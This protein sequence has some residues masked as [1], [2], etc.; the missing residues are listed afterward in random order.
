MPEEQKAI[1]SLKAA[2]ISDTKD[3]DLR[4]LF[5]YLYGLIGLL[6]ERFPSHSQEMILIDYVRSEW[7]KLRLDEIKLAYQ[8][9]ISGK[10]DVSPEHFQSFSAL[11]FGK[12]ISVYVLWASQV[13]IQNMKPFVKAAPPKWQIEIEYC[14]FRQ[15]DLKRKIN[16]PLKW[17]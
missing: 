7:G 16:A 17:I 10:L 3:S 9:A 1:D 8:M 2:R 15:C 13:H 12:I 6:P 11:Y 4:I 5:L 14:F